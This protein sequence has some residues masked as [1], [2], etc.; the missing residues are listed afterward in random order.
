[1]SI[2]GQVISPDAEKAF[3]P[4]EWSFVCYTLEKFGLADNFIKW[5]QALCNGSYDKRV[6][7]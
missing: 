4:V 2:D 6:K 3:I 1:M 5:V 7:I